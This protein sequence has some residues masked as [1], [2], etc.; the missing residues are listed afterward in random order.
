MI[1]NYDEFHEQLIAA[2]KF[3]SRNY[4]NTDCDIDILIQTVYNDI[5]DNITLEFT[6]T[7]YIL[8][9][10]HDIILQQWLDDVVCGEVMQIVDS[11]YKDITHNFQRVGLM[12]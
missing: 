1:K 8:T 10:G 3:R 2:V 6:E 4:V 5:A 11:D 12:A 7:E 9:D